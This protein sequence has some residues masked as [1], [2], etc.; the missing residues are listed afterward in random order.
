[1]P[2][3]PPLLAKLREKIRALTP[4]ED[5]PT[6]PARIEEEKGE[7]AEYLQ[8]HREGDGFLLKMFRADESGEMVYCDS[9][10]TLQDI[11]AINRCIAQTELRI[12]LGFVWWS[13]RV[14]P[15]MILGIERHEGMPDPYGFWACRER[16]AA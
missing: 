16:K 8:L 12:P 15:T 5:A 10:A 2:L 4:E 11:G 1:M 13:T 9:L 7:K 6:M 14:V 3:E